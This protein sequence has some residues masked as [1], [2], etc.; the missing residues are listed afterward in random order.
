MK[1]ILGLLL[2]VAILAI[3][4][5][6]TATADTASVHP[7]ARHLGD[8][9]FSDFERLQLLCSQSYDTSTHNPIEYWS[10]TE[11][12]PF[13]I[14]EDLTIPSGM[15]LYVREGSLQIPAGITLTANGSVTASNLVVDGTLILNNNLS[16]SDSL[17]ITGTVVSNG[18]INIE[19]DTSVIGAERITDKHGSQA[20]I[21][22]RCTFEN[23]AELKRIEE[24]ATAHPYR[25]YQISRTDT[26]GAAVVT[27][28][29]ESVTLPSNSELTINY[30][31]DIVI[32]PNCTFT[33]DGDV[34]LNGSLTVEGSL[35]NNSTIRLDYNDEASLTFA[36]TGTYSG[37]GTI[38][39]IDSSKTLENVADAVIGLDLTNFQ[40][41][42]EFNEW[43][44]QWELR[45]LNS[46]TKLAAPTDL[47]WGYDH[48]RYI[49]DP[50][51]QEQVRTTVA[52]PGTLSWKPADPTQHGFF[53]V[54]VYQE[55]VDEPYYAT[56]WG[57]NPDNSDGWCSMPELSLTE[58]DS[59]NYYFTVTAIPDGNNP[60]LA[61]SDTVT[62]G[63]WCYEK[64]D[65]RLDLCTDLF[66]DFPEYHFNDPAQGKNVDRYEI[67]LCHAE[68]EETRPWCFSHGLYPTS[69]TQF[70]IDE[71]DIDRLGIGY[72]YFQV[73]PISSDI[74]KVLH[75]EWTDLSPAYYMDTLTLGGQLAQIYGNRKHMS[76]E[77]I[78][79][80]VQ[81]LDAEALSQK[82]LNNGGSELDYI[83][84]LE[85]T[86]GGPVNVI[87][88][89]SLIDADQ[90]AVIGA[91]LNN[92]TDTNTQISLIIDEL[93]YPVE[94]D[95]TYDSSVAMKL[96][97]SLSN[98]E[99][100]V[101]VRVELPV[102]KNIHSN[103]LA[104]LQI[105]PDGIEELPATIMYAM[106]NCYAIVVLTEPTDIVITHRNQICSHVFE[107]FCIQESTCEDPG[108]Y[109]R[110]CVICGIE[111]EAE[112][113]PATGHSW[114]AGTVTTEPTATDSGVMTY[115]CTVCGAERTEEIP[116]M[117]ESTLWGDVNGDGF[118]DSFD[119]SLI[120]K[121]DVLLITDSDLDLSAADVSGDGF[122]DSYDASLIL[123]FDVLLID[124]FPAEA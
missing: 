71:Y 65:S 87:S 4:L 99:L 46:L 76:A 33:T 1:R 20:N 121:Y 75:G 68:T 2:L 38:S 64:P 113:I 123:K 59:G 53:R 118:V 114:D 90:T 41:T 22:I 16:V 61:D 37:L 26:Y 83:I 9:L 78:R 94:L 8:Y 69:L 101:P 104:I 25:S 7:G 89:T 51:T 105:S 14:E 107:E 96:A 91:N 93:N 117:G 18:W 70:S 19:L 79:S 60:A 36:S 47:E 111:C 44:Y 63:I 85:D 50:V 6:L 88:N 109:Q 15:D 42:E 106:G 97:L 29:D 57:F 32:A 39:V 74:T 11:N 45:D 5:P 24:A 30:Q 119:A 40:I 48:N 82:L 103:D 49:F 3:N 12:A 108:L 86:I 56:E 43:Y 35:V 73:R 120:M 10:L 34:K 72:F 13:I 115:I 80:A 23:T 62:S 122:V 27:T 58:I 102:S 95:S 28:I 17:A 66:W 92:A 112:E 110:Y 31:D 21:D 81:A 54:F 100:Q 77:E 55:G 98:T 67:K 84:R 124:K 52:I 116:A